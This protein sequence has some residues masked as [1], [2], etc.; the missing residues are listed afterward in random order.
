MTKVTDVAQVRVW[1]DEACERIERIDSAGGLTPSQQH[2]NALLRPREARI[3]HLCDDL[4]EV[5]GD[6][7]DDRELTP[8][9]RTDLTEALALAY[10]RASDARQKLVDQILA[11]T[12][13]YGQDRNLWPVNSE[14]HLRQFERAIA[15]AAAEIVD[16]EATLKRG[17]WL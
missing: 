9:D 3:L 1:R 6:T 11:T 12:K 16:T 2:L 17:A 8:E 7:D 15:G 10:S 13:A 5:L 4:L 14:M